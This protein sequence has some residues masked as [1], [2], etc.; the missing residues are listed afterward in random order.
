MAVQTRSVLK[1]YFETGDKP[2]ATQFGDL[3]DSALMA[4]MVQTSD[5]T[6]TVAANTTYWC[7]ASHIINVKLDYINAGEC[8]VVNRYSSATIANSTVK[9]TGTGKTIMYA[10]GYSDVSADNTGCMSYAILVPKSSFALVNRAFY[11]TE[12]S[13]EPELGK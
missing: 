8:C 7:T 11:K 9:F 3:I 4:N 10:A 6:I 13:G 12:L 2:T 1:T 5:R